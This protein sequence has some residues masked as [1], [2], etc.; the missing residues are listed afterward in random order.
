MYTVKKG[1]LGRGLDSL[2]EENGGL[3]EQVSSHNQARLRIMDLEPNPEQPRQDFDDEALAELSRSIAA[4]GVLQP[5][6]VR[7]MPNGAYQIIAGERR[8][9]ASRAAGLAEVPVVIKELSDEEAMAA[10]LIENLQREDLNPMEEAFGFQKLM[11]TFDLTQEEAARKVGKSRPVVANALRLLK[12]PEIVAELLRE[13]KISTGHARAL[14]GLENMGLMETLAQDIVAEQLSVREVE[15]IV[16]QQ[17]K[18]ASDLME[19]LNSDDVFANAAPRRLAFFDEVQL[20]LEQT[21]GRKIKVNTAGQSESGTLVIDFFDQD[22]LKNIANMLE[23]R[24]R[25][26]TEHA[27][28][29]V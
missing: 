21:L 18:L 2:F 16:K 6:L 11:T 22:D 4:H 9:R 24:E 19:R 8:W 12:L 1:G 7:P 26:P 15:R 23:T 3:E 20:S 28:P 5:I 13:N 10:A 25:A 27:I 17:N 14:L 29:G